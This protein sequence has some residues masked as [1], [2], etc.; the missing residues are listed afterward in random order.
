MEYGAMGDR[1]DES[2][3]VRDADKETDILD[4]HRRIFNDPGRFK[5]RIVPSSKRY[6]ITLFLNDCSSAM[7]K[8]T[9]QKYLIQGFKRHPEIQFEVQP[10]FFHLCAQLALKGYKRSGLGWLSK[11]QDKCR[12]FSSYVGRYVI[13]DKETKNSYHISVDGSDGRTVGDFDALKWSDIY[14]KHNYW[15]SMSYPEQ[16][17][18]RPLI[19]GDGCLSPKFYKVLI[20]L[21]KS[22]KFLDFIYLTKIWKPDSNSHFT[23]E[24][25]DNI[26]EHQ[27]RLYETLSQLQ[28]NKHLGVELTHGF[29]KGAETE[30]VIKRLSS[31]GVLCRPHRLN[32]REFWNLHCASKIV[33]ARPG[34][35]LCTSFR[36]STFLMIGACIAY[37]AEPFVHWYEP[38]VPG[39][40]YVQGNCGLD[41]NY[42]LPDMSSYKGIIN[43]VETLLNN[44]EKRDRLSRNA[45]KYYD[46]YS[47][48]LN[49][50]HYVIRCC[51]NLSTTKTD[52]AA[53]G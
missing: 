19:N 11:F 43:M 48:P 52:G 9:Y 13:I 5:K 37:D 22:E 31:V 26:V 40:H 53:L 27:V 23:L 28:C 50:A 46:T 35:H 14:F 4:P 20:Q 38:L 8:L 10:I 41:K 1:L 18:L 7:S 32:Q 6:K 33:F 2:I 39:F 12:N 29:F 36:I 51:G 30:K 16:H 21:R 34:D 25:C 44:P 17:K 47:N 49:L 3:K 45:A 15:P 42:G 24:Q